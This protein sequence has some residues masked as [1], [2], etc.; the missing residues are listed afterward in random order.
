MSS[1]PQRSRHTTGTARRTTAHHGPAAVRHHTALRRLVPRAL[2]VAFLAGGTCALLTGGNE[3]DPAAHE[4]P[5]ALAFAAEPA[6][7]VALT[8]SP[9]G[10]RRVA[11]EPRDILVPRLAPLPAPR[12]VTPRPGTPAG[13]GAPGGTGA[14]APRRARGALPAPRGPRERSWAAAG[15]RPGSGGGTVTAQVPRR[16]ARA[17][18]PPPTAVLSAAGA[19]GHGA[20]TGSQ[21]ADA[22]AAAAWSGAADGSG[23]ESAA[24]AGAVLPGWDTASVDPGGFPRD[25]QGISVLPQITGPAAATDSGWPSP[26]PAPAPSADPAGDAG[27]G[28]DDRSTA[29]TVGPDGIGD[30]SPRPAPQGPPADRTPATELPRPPAEGRLPAGRPFPRP[31]RGRPVPGRHTPAR[32]IPV[33]RPGRA[34]ALAVERLDWRRLA[35]CEASGRPHAVD[36]SGTYGGLYQFDLLTWH[37][38]GGRGRPQDATAAEQTLLAKRLYSRRGAG[39]WPVC[40]SRLFR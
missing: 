19:A 27:S 18:H 26:S 20:G 7:A 33:R 24:W 1:R 35:F 14:G 37:S 17:E 6:E 9:S 15:H 2:V 22:G 16:R 21:V 13:H 11:V 39:P 10:E 28:G 32:D 4:G 29:G 30:P 31:A 23:N 40:G 12:L 5:P 25:S 36:P 3:L 38:L 8:A 34:L